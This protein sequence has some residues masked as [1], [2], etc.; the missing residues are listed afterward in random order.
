M[1]APCQLSTDNSPLTTAS[2]TSLF[3]R[4]ILLL[5]R[6][7][8]SGAAEPCEPRQVREEATVSESLW[9]PPGF[10]LGCFLFNKNAPTDFLWERFYGRTAFIE[11]RF[12]R[13]F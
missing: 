1:Q 9:A 13:L 7:G 3:S 11:L 5:K 4:G 2:L 12:Y 8:G 10:L 6:L